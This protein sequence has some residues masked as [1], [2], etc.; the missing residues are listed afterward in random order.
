MMNAFDQPQTILVLGGRSD[1]AHAI[2]REVA[3]PALRTVVLAQRSTQPSGGDGELAGLGSDVQAVA[4][5][6]DA[7]DHASHAGLI[8]QIAADHGDLDVVIQAFGQLGGNDVNT[9]PIAAGRLAD[10][11]FS[12]AVSSG[13]AVADRLR[14]QG[15][16]VLVVLSS[17]AGVRTR[18]SNFVYGATKAGQ[19]AFAT[20]LGHS[21]HGS[22]ARVM[23]VRPGFVR[24]AMTEG[25]DE[26]PF[27]CDPSDV[28]KA[29]ADGLRRK[30][31]VVWA[32]GILRY[33]FG[34]LRIVPGPVWRKLDR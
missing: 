3:S 13:I 2:V 16:G 34:A 23:T 21:L 11:N 20:G 5:D 33:V 1:I 6:F 8:E 14:R 32:P 24:S 27:A 30:K 12:G 18:P 4:V 28:A 9:D 29:V 15:H 26:A 17:V 22:G 19:D 7:T 10:V 25:L 31:S